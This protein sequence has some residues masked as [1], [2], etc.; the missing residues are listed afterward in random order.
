MENPVPVITVD[1]IEPVD[2]DSL[3][4][5]LQ[6][7][8]NTFIEMIALGCRRRLSAKKDLC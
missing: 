2:I 3:P 7:G 5:D 1:E 6:E 8:W 4:P